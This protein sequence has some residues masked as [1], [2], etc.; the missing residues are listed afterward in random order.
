MLQLFD[1][2]VLQM[3]GVQPEEIKFPLLKD[4]EGNFFL[5]VYVKCFFDMGLASKSNGLF[6]LKRALKFIAGF[7]V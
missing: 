1:E 4:L 7:V 3:G 2:R 6:Y 5:F